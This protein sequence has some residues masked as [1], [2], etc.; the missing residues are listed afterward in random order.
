MHLSSY[1]RVEIRCLSQ[2]QES[3]CFIN[4]RNM[5]LTASRK[6]QLWSNLQEYQLIINLKVQ[7]LKGKC[8]IAIL[9]LLQ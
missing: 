7:G 4:I 6:Y 1:P 8:Q 9:P 2:A 5:H 3:K